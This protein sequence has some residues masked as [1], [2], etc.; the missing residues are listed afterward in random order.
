M[1][2]RAAAAPAPL[3]QLREG[4]TMLS[5][6][7]DKQKSVLKRTI[8]EL[9]D[10][11]PD[12][13]ATV[14]TELPEY[15]FEAVVEHVQGDREVSA[16]FRYVCHAWREAHDRLV[17][18]LK[19]SGAPP[20]ASIWKKFGGVKTVVL[21]GYFV[22]DDDLRGLTPLA[23][24]LTSLD[25]QHCYDIT[26]KGVKALAPLTAI[27]SLDLTGCSRVT[28]MGIRALAPLTALT[29]LN[30]FRCFKVTDKGLRALAPFTALTSLNL[31][32]CEGVSNE[33]MRALLASRTGIGDFVMQKLTFPSR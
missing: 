25:L 12:S 3:H 17:T 2:A 4:P 6:K 9:N 28:D 24:T 32:Y 29:S 19:P 18:V 30:L 15:V 14:W 13:P 33:G 23:A 22:K 7:V 11:V 16:N 27:T 10:T 26:N 20:D 31:G 21:K 5:E 8:Q 1:G